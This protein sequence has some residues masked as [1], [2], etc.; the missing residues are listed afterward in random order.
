[1]SQV[2]RLN[3]VILPVIVS[4]LA[5]CGVSAETENNTNNLQKSSLKVEE[6]EKESENET[7]VRIKTSHGDVVIALYNETP[8]HYQIG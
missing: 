5:A 7:K 8:K 1:M 4:F 3:M 2:K 6:I